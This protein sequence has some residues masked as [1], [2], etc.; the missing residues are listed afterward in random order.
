MQTSAAERHVAPICGPSGCSMP[1]PA[2]AALAAAP[3]GESGEIGS[4]SLEPRE[5]DR[6]RDE[7]VRASPGAVGFGDGMQLLRERRQYEPFLKM[8]QARPT[9]PLMH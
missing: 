4:R 6:E 8:G 2:H 3:T 7:T 9:V 5:R 1:R